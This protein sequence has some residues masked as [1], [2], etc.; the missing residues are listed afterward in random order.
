MELRWWD[1]TKRLPRVSE[2]RFLGGFQVLCLSLFEHFFIAGIH[3]NA[4]LEPVED[5]F[6]HRKTWEDRADKTDLMDLKVM[7]FRSPPSV[8]MEPQILFKYP[9]GKRLSMRLGDLASFCFHTGVM[10]TNC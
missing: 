2:I 7:Q 8:T 9:P 4:N 6:A 5:A 10:V 1:F 3:P